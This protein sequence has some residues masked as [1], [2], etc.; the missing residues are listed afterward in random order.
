MPIFLAEAL[1][2]PAAHPL[3]TAG[4]RKIPA[5][6]WPICAILLIK[7]QQCKKCGKGGVSLKKERLDKILAAQGTWTRKDVRALT[8]RGLVTCNGAPCLRADTKIDPDS[9]QIAVQGRPILLKRHLYLMLHKPAGVVS[10]TRDDTRPTVVDL[11][12]PELRRRGLFPAGRLDRDTTGFVLITDDGELA[13][14]ILAPKNHIPKTY[15]V[16][17][18]RPLPPGLPERFAAGMVLDGGE[19][20][21]PAQLEVLGERRARVVL[22]QGMYHQIKRMFAAQGCQVVALHRSAMG[23]LPLDPDLAPGECRELTPQELA[24]LE[25]VATP[26]L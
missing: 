7:G 25:K 2:R 8:S 4:G 6:T 9:D 22:H 18:D 24:L 3:P 10:A 13:H 11:V 12:S 20:C 1:R 5:Q 15:L 14:R 19:T 17:L 23:A 16:T 26:G 21:L